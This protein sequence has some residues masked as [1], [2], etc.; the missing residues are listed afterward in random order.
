MAAELPFARVIGV[1][2]SE[3]LVKAAQKNLSTHRNFNLKCKHIEVVLQD[4]ITYEF[5]ADPLV[6]YS[7]N[8]FPPA[9]T[10]V[11]VDNLKRSVMQHPRDI[12]LIWMPT[13]PEIESL[14][15]ECG[16]LRLVDTGS[17]YKIYQTVFP[18]VRGA[19]LTN[20]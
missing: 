15:S 12:Y 4:A 1:E 2:L 9:I 8:T 17:S 13:S 20:I 11:V 16:F 14:F 10:K 6:I 18:A 19:E 3:K 7:L 5:P